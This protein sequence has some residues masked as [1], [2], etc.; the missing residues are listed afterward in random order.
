MRKYELIVNCFFDGSECEHDRRVFETEREAK[1]YY[2]AEHAHNDG[3]TSHTITMIN[4]D[5][6]RSIFDDV[7]K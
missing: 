2:L 6:S 4:E 1:S 7:D 5:G 3:V